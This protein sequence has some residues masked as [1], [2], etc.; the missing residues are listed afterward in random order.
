MFSSL[1]VVLPEGRCIFFQGALAPAIGCRDLVSG[2]VREGLNQPLRTDTS[3]S[4]TA[5]MEVGA[6]NVLP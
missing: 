5:R 4:R 6:R 2:T 1:Q 3:R